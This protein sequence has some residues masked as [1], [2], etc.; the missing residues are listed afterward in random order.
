M[1]I[2]LFSARFGKFQEVDFILLLTDKPEI[3]FENFKS[4]VSAYRKTDIKI[5]QKFKKQSTEMGRTFLSFRIWIRFRRKNKA[6]KIKKKI[7]LEEMKWRLLLRNSN[8]G[9]WFHHEEYIAKRQLE[10]Y[11][12]MQR[13]RKNTGFFK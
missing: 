10:K 13:N 12:K 8:Q 9:D 6:S 11:Q 5:C 7:P 1:L 3:I 2:S 4:A